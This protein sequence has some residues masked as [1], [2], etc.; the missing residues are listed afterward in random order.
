MKRN[1]QDVAL[2]I[3]R[4]IVGAIFLYHGWPKLLNQPELLGFPGFFGFLIGIIEVLF[5]ILLILG[6]GFPWA[7][8]PLM[9]VII[10]ALLFVQLPRGLTVSSERDLLVLMSLIILHAFGQGKYAIQKTFGK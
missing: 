4:L 2:F 1:T 3:L 5:G 9:A 6:V 10:V 7:V 8:Y